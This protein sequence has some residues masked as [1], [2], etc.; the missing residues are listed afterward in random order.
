[1][2]ELF[3]YIR[4]L[5]IDRLAGKSFSQ[6]FFRKSEL[7]GA[8]QSHVDAALSV[9]QIEDLVDPD[10]ASAEVFETLLK[11]KAISHKDQEFAGRYFRFNNLQLQSFRSSYLKNDPVAQAAQEIG[12]RF[13]Q[14]V[15]DGFRTSQG[16]DYA[17]QDKPLPASVIKQQDWSE[18]SS[19]IDE[20]DIGEIK[21]KVSDLTRAI[22]QSDL[23]DRTKRNALARAE[24]VLSLLDA[25][26]PPWEVIVELL[27][28]RYFTA[29]LNTMAIF[30]LIMGGIS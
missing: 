6:G 20:K 29:I 26:D 21:S 28:N 3:P 23:D 27:N 1:M 5:V 14:D 2:K 10:S 11:G 16:P 19:R 22:E 25:P 7:V 15:F 8:I 24:S 30:Q 4:T 9:Y 13:F 17:R 18:I 12:D